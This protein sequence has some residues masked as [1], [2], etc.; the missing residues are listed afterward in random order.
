M[1]D[2]DTGA[3]S[4]QA[5][6]L[7]DP[8]PP[9]V[10][11]PLLQARTDG[12]HAAHLQ[13]L[14]RLAAE[15]AG[16]QR[17]VRV[18]FFVP[19]TALWDVFASI[20]LAMQAHPGFDVRVVAFQ[21]QG[22]QTDLS[23]H[24]TRA[25]YAAIGVPVDLYGFDDGPV[26]V[27]GPADLDVAFYTLGSTAYPRPFQIEFLSLFC[28]TVYIPYGFLQAAEYEY[29]FN[30]TFHHAAWRVVANTVRERDCYTHYSDR[31]SSHVVVARYP[32]FDLFSGADLAGPERPVVIWAPHWSVGLSYPRLNCGTFCDIY[33][34][35]MMLMGA[36]P[37]IDFV[38]KP[39]PLLSHGLTISGFMSQA[40]YRDYVDLIAALPNVTV[41]EHGAYVDL[42]ERS[43][44]MITDSI[45]FLAEYVLAD[46]PLLFL[47][48]PD[49]ARFSAQGEAIVA[50][51]QRGL[52]IDAIRS[53][54]ETAVLQGQDVMAETRRSQ[55]GTLLGLDHPPTAETIIEHI[56]SCV[57][58]GRDIVHDSV[59]P[60]R[61]GPLDD[62]QLRAFFADRSRRYSDAQPYTA[63]LYQDHNPDL[64]RRRD[65]YEKDK[66]LPLL[67]AQ[68]GS[69]VLDVGCGIG[70]WADALEP[71]E[72]RYLGVDLDAGMIEHARARIQRKG[73][74]FEVAD[75]AYLETCLARLTD[76]PDAFDIVIIAGVMLYMADAGVASMLRAALSRVA[77]GGVVYI[78]EP[79]AVETELRLNGV[80]SQELQAHYTAYYRQRDHA[81][82]LVTRVCADLP[83]GVGAWAM[84]GQ[85]IFEPL[86]ADGGLDNRT[87]TRQFFALLRR[88]PA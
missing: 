30:Q 8:L 37:Q 60:S 46:R 69:R 24:E 55:A 63:V 77:P 26:P 34:D 28:L 74:A 13:T 12:W 11:D 59:R 22:V 79:L 25:F 64:A 44:A 27:F 86:Y 66:V 9:K 70:R 72:C 80:W 73:V 85:T 5:R 7:T 71:V 38:F 10:F 15:G 56:L 84:A 88:N 33:H 2:K 76:A 83:G 75:A 82:E 19:D 62:N 6:D 48:R 51:H 40:Q 21:R 32:K 68:D 41:Y 17:P 61:S 52:G 50:L 43:A 67:A 45:S 23:A 4:Q 65:A 1:L 31:R 39:H 87:E 78:R 18:V 16:H 47:D 54:I 3:G 81:A 57:R 36:H 49:R 53:F 14:H 35:M 42:F 58:L 29:Q 20:Y